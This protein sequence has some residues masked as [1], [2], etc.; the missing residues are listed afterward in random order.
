M[1]ELGDL[2][3]YAMLPFSAS[4]VGVRSGLTDILG[5][6]TLFIVWLCTKDVSPV[7]KHGPRSSDCMQVKGAMKP[8]RHREIK[9]FLKS[10]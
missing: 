3:F 2:W 9:G 1:S 6:V 8:P 7:L 4:A 5:L 10:L